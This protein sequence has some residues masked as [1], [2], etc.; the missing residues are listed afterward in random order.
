M[1]SEPP[2]LPVS[3]VDR[4]Y[5]RGLAEIIASDIH[6]INNLRVLRYLREPMGRSAAEVTAWYNHWIAKGFA[7]IESILARDKRAGAFG[8]GERPTLVDICLVPQVYNGQ[9]YGLD[10]SQYPTIRRIFRN[11]ENLAPFADAHPDRQPD[12]ERR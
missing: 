6:P 3:P 7:K 4:A 2:L 12:A 5:V 8:F 9:I 10:L 1:L 11:C